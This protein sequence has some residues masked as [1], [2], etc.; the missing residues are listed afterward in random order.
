MSHHCTVIC[1]PVLLAICGP[2][3]KIHRSRED[4]EFTKVNRKAIRDTELPSKIYQIHLKYVVGTM[5]RRF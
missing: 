1:E 5:S 3:M 4:P 2:E